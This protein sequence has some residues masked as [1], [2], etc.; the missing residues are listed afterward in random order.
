MALKGTLVLPLFVFVRALWQA[1]CVR[2]NNYKLIILINFNKKKTLIVSI[3]I[4]ILGNL[5]HCDSALR[6][7]WFS[8]LLCMFF[9]FFF[10]PSVERQT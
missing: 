2:K 9:F 5:F 10:P 1:T 4:Q 3:L 6:W 8:E 7:A